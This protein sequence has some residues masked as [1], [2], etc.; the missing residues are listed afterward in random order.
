[1]TM[2]RRQWF[3]PVHP[4]GLNGGGAHQVEN[5]GWKDAAAVL[6]SRLLF[7]NRLLANRWTAST[8][9]WRRMVCERFPSPRDGAGI[10]IPQRNAVPSEA[11]TDWLEAG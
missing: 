10:V 11:K 2:R 4:C 8:R 3:R 1:M 7:T 6:D 9:G 5:Y